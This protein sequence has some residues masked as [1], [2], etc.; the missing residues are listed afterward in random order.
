MQS[1]ASRLEEHLGSP[2]KAPEAGPLG[3]PVFW[4]TA[5]GIEVACIEVEA[6][7]RRELIDAWKTQR[8]G[9]ATPLLLL[10]QRDSALIAVGP[11]GVEPEPVE[12]LRN[13]L[14]DSSF[15][16]TVAIAR[17]PSRVCRCFSP[18]S[19][20]TRTGLPGIRPEGLLTPHF[21]FERLPQTHF[22]TS[23]DRRRPH[24]QRPTGEP[25]SNSSVMSFET[26]TDGF[27]AKANGNAIVVVR[28]PPR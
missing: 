14:I 26:L 13:F 17:P 10:I 2:R 15:C 9:Q 6:A 20:R 3:T 25:F 12:V 5:S 7:R 8:R 23:C 11:E 24:T 21:L 1:L 4:P 28:V 27:I 18:T 16:W 22:G 19:Q